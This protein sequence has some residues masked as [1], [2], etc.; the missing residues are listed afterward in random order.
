MR[1]LRF[2][3]SLLLMIGLTGLP[4]AARAA[5]GGGGGDYGGSVGSSPSS[6]RSP[7]SVARRHYQAGLRAKAKAWKFEEKAAKEDDAEDR[8]KL[9]AKAQKAYAGAIRSQTAAVKAFAKHYEAL[10]ELGYALRRTGQFTEAI[11]A[12]DRALAINSAYFPAIEYRGEAYLATGELEKVKSAYMV[13]F[14]NE[15]ALADQLMTA[16]DAWLAEQPEGDGKA[17]FAAWIDER[18]ALAKVGSDLS[19][20]NTRRW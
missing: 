11:A 17:S 2:V 12:Y 10:N 1:R 3:A 20:N 5:G 7:E 18:K 19:Q 15:R 8:E 6:S 14:R 4:L 16:M 13:L 9:L